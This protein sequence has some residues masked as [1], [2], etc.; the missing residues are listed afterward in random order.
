MQ[1]THTRVAF[2]PM[3]L[4]Q[5]KPA[6]NQVSRLRHVMVDDGDALCTR[7][8]FANEA[9]YSFDIY[10]KHRQIHVSVFPTDVSSV[11]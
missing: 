8:R 9:H 5:K 6:E 1:I 4:I 11:E 2:G 7:L 3:R 10:G